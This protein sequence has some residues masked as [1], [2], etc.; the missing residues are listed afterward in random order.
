MIALLKVLP[1]NKY[2][3]ALY[4]YANVLWYLSLWIKWSWLDNLA[5]GAHYQI[6]AEEIERMENAKQAKKAFY[7]QLAEQEQ[8]P[9]FKAIYGREPVAGQDYD[10]D[11]SF[12]RDD[13]EFFT[14]TGR[15]SD[16]VAPQFDYGVN[17]DLGE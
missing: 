14:G 7:D 12:C 4:V 5:A 17:D 9:S 16:D 1:Y 2:M 11:G 10:P 8:Y 15:Y 6:E 13:Y 3:F